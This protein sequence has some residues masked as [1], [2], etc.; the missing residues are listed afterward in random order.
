MHNIFWLGDLKGRDYLE[1]IGLDGV[2]I[3]EWIL[4]KEDGKLWTG[5]IWLRIGISGG[6]L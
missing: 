3:L 1:H 5:F 2:I 4:G 6:L